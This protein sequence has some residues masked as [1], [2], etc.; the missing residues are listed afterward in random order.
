[1]RRGHA[2]ATKAPGYEP[3]DGG[4]YDPAGIMAPSRWGA[5]APSV[6]PRRPKAARAPVPPPITDRDLAEA[7]AGWFE[8]ASD[9]ALVRTGSDA[10]RLGPVA[11][12][13]SS[14]LVPGVFGWHRPVR[15]GNAG[16]RSTAELYYLVGN[17]GNAGGGPSPI[18]E[19]DW[20]EFAAVERCALPVA[21]FV[22]ARGPSSL[23]APLRK[24]A[25]LVCQELAETDD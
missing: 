20:A 5:E 4:R 9:H 15:S 7:G 16:P 11:P 19:F 1:M 3:I 6:A 24:L 17:G 12:L 2:D 23:A 22:L 18:R 10:L 25:A 14:G 13:P 8:E 21:G